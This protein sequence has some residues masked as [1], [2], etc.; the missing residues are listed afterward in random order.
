MCFETCSRKL[1]DAHRLNLKSMVHMHMD[2]TMGCSRPQP[3]VELSSTLLAALRQR[4]LS[5]GCLRS[6]AHVVCRPEQGDCFS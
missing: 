3:I 1:L 2:S 4:H 6:S 5:F